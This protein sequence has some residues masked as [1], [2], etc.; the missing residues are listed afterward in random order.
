VLGAA[1][2]WLEADSDGDGLGD[3][4][5]IDENG[6]GNTDGIAIDLNGD[7]FYDG[8]DRD[9]DGNADKI[10]GQPVG[11]GGAPSTGGTTGSGGAP[12]AS[13]GAVGSGGT[14]NLAGSCLTTAPR[15]SGGGTITGNN[16]AARYAKYD[17]WRQNCED[18]GT[19]PAVPYKFIANGWGTNW[20]SHTIT[21]GGAKFS[22]DAFAGNND[23]GAPAGYPT[24]FCGTYSNESSGACGLPA[25]IST[26]TEIDTGL[27]WSHSGQGSDYNVAYDIWMGNGNSFVGFLMVWYR[28]PPANQPA[29][30]LR[31]NNIFVGPDTQRWDV[32]TGTVNGAP[33]VNYVRPNGEESMEY[34]FDAMDFVEHAKANYQLPGDT[35][36]SVAIGF[37]IWNGPVSN[38]VVEDFCVEV[39]KN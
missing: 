16:D 8:I 12:P 15:H 29:G 18:T 10:T 37:E 1:G 32:W 19:C 38:L 11:S 26:I 2:Q 14:P 7:G 5:A 13:G 17:T 34:A 23:A 20:Q 33:I 31:A 39:H 24:V 28:D 36:L 21:Y 9:G 25:P 22:V 6:D 30:S 27:R 35:V 4:Y 3:G